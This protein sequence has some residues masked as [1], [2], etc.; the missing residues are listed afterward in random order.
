MT[1]WAATVRWRDC[2]DCLPHRTVAVLP[3]NG[4]AIQVTLALVS[5]APPGWMRRIVWPP[6]IRSKDVV[7]G[8]EGLP[9]RIGVYQSYV[10]VGRYQTAVWAF[11]GRGRPSPSQLRAV[12]AELAAARIPS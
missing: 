1:T 8:F 12:N 4:I 2:A 5:S 6:R 9:T 3:P 10:L 11:F 7:A